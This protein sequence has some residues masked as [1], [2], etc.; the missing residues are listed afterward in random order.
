MSASTRI[1]AVKGMH[2]VLPQAMA[3][4]KRVE[5]LFRDLAERHG[6]AE[7]RTPL[8]EPTSLFVRS[9]GESTDIVGKEMYS[10]VD[11]GE[12][13]LTL[14]PEGTASAVRAYI[15]HEI[16][17]QE[18][19]TKWYYIGPMFRRERPARGRY[20]QFWQAGIECFGDPGP[21]SDAEAIALLVEVLR[22]IG[23]SELEVVVNSIG[24]RSSKERY[25]QALV[26]FLKPHKEALSLESQ[27]RLETNPLRILDSKDPKDQ[28]ICKNAPAILDFLS[29]Q[30]RAHFESLCE[31]LAR[32]GIES[33]V[34]PHLVRGL[35]Y[36]SRTL[37]EV[38]GKGGEL[39]AQNA[40]AGGGRYDE[41]V[42]ALGGPPTPA[43]GFAMG[44]ERI[45]LACENT[46]EGPSLDVWVATPDP[47]LLPC[48]LELLTLLRRDGIR[49][50][51]DLR[52]TSLRS[53]L[54][55]AQ[56][57]GVPF[58]LLLGP[59]EEAKSTFRLKDMEGHSEE[60]IPQSALF[61]ELKR[62]L[63]KRSPS[64]L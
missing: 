51:A 33:R 18:A 6:Y 57:K 29:E 46:Q 56:K 40:L 19:V 20:R 50:D 5:A 43:I 28:A 32:L 54:R 7:I 53:Q 21:Y 41:L 10:F 64:A 36:Y 61:F 44:I 39:G 62:R 35:D 4:W 34:D 24:S 31:L 23:L 48:V 59:E 26:E 60:E 63:P 1:R 14:R 42:E 13:S 9:I 47:S 30:D 16:H 52:G 27:R 11:K 17:A 49:A 37:F 22:A 58:V 2:D 3:R 55:R 15:E 12:D 45:L 25:R 38:R 8:V